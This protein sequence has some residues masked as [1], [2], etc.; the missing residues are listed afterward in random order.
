MVQFTSWSKC[1]GNLEQ[2][3]VRQYV[4]VFVSIC[5]VA[6]S[7]LRCRASVLTTSP[8]DVGVGSVQQH[9]VN[10]LVFMHHYCQCRLYAWDLR[11]VFWK[12]WKLPHEFPEPSRSY[13][14]VVVDYVTK[15][16]E[17]EAKWNGWIFG[18]IFRKGQQLHWTCRIT[19]SW[20]GFNV[21]IAFLSVTDDIVG[22]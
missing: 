10:R 5:A 21:T 8:G 14:G 11:T 1:D 3:Y 7:K 2:L 16:G 19:W 13:V 18:S 9:I 15:A 22:S 6:K 4:R 12:W 20:Y 17:Y